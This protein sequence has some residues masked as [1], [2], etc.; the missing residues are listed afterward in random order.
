MKKET[1]NRQKKI[2]RASLL[3][4]I[5]NLLF[6]LTKIII[7]AAASSLAIISEG[8]NNAAD[9]GSSLLTLVGTRLSA[10]H[11]DKKHPFGYGRIEYLTSLVVSLLIL[12]T[13]FIK[14]NSI[15]C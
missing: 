15:C 3:G 11:P 7:G 1:E 12:Y 14:Y 5:A 4:V 9:A 6:A 2:V 8:V 10:K 13:G